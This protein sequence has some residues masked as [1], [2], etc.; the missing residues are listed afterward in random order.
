M[1][2]KGVD[3]FAKKGTEVQAA[4]GG[5]VFASGYN[6]VAGNFLVVLGPKWRFHYYAHLDEKLVG[7]FA[8]VSRGE[9][10]GKVGDTGNAAGKAPHSHYAIV[11]PIP[12]SWRYS[13]GPHGSRKMFYLDPTPHL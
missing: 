10:I 11:T 3:I 8:W 12:Y 5:L 6:H 1:V 9:A 4:T 2:H 7:R 13:D